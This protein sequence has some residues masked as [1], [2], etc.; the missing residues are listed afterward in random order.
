MQNDTASINDIVTKAAEENKDKVDAGA[1]GSQDN[2]QDDKTDLGAAGAGDDKKDTAAADNK[3]VVVEDKVANLLKELGAESLDELKEKLAKAGEKKLTP[4]EEAKAKEVYEA[5]LQEYAVANGKMKLEDFQQLNTLKSKQDADL[6]FESYKKDFIEEESKRLKEE[7]DNLTDKD[8]EE[9]A[10]EEF[11][12][13]Y[14]LNSTSEKQKQKGIQRLAKEAAEF[15]NPLES[16]YSN[17]KEEFDAETDVRQNFPKFVETLSGLVK[18]SVPEKINYYK[19]T[20]G[21]T[22]IDIEVELTK[23]EI[24]GIAEKVN[25]RIQNPDTYALFKEG[26]KE[27]LKNLVSEYA[28]YLT[29]KAVQEKGKSKIAEIYMGLG[30]KKGST[31][32]AENSFA[33]NQSKGAAHS[34]KQSPTDKEQVVLGQFGVKK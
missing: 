18:E 9:L 19:G 30:V 14:K 33:V 5:K 23:E 6:V 11:E 13:E 12:K 25:K 1:A 28:D 27:E 22:A 8:I 16:S 10:K 15:R 26:K 3:D 17:V 7:D 34:N 32:G 20:D 2:K 29:E 24:D 31:V 4:E 21:D